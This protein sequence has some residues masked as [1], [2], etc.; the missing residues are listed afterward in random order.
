MGK[1]LEY[2]ETSTERG[3]ET[4]NQKLF[5]DSYQIS[6]KQS[7]LEANH[8][9]TMDRLDRIVCVDRGDSLWRI[10]KLSL[11]KEYAASVAENP[12]SDAEVKSKVKEI[13]ALNKERYPSIAGAGHPIF[14]GQILQVKAEPSEEEKRLARQEYCASLDWQQAPAGKTTHAGECQKVKAAASAKVIAHEGSE[15]MAQNGSFVLA[16]K[17]SK[18]KALHGSR[19]ANYGGDVEA[20]NGALVL[21]VN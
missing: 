14:E 13:V 4:V 15:V 9:E 17:G 2:Q 10:A 11:E 7:P 8:K 20:W 1:T 21:D 19:V 16:L 18:V 6:V 5:E 3:D 12:I